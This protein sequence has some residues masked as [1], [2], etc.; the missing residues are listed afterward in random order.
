MSLVPDPTLQYVL[1]PL[2]FLFFFMAVSS[3]VFLFI[4]LLG[5][6]GVLRHRGERRSRHAGCLHKINVLASQTRHQF[7]TRCTFSKEKLVG[8]AGHH[9]TNHWPNPV[10]LEENRRRSNTTEILCFTTKAYYLWSQL[11]LYKS[12]LYI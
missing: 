11:P 4:V 10:N 8:H 5:S 2:F 6:G 3:V 1:C 7:L 9:C 12:K